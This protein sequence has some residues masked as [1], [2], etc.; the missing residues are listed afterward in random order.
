MLVSSAAFLMFVV[1][2]VIPVT[3]DISG[4]ERD[5]LAFLWESYRSIENPVI[6]IISEI[7][8]SMQTVAYTID[9]IPAVRPF[10]M[11]VS[12]LYAL[13]TV[14]PNVFGQGVHPAIAHGI[15]ADWLVWQVNPEIAAEGG[16]LGYSFIAEAFLNFGWLGAPVMLALIG[17]GLA[18]VF[19]W[20]DRS[21]NRLNIALAAIFVAFLSHFARGESATI[22]RPFVWYGLGPY[23]L[24]GMLSGLLTCWQTAPEHP[25]R[26]GGAPVATATVGSPER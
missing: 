11:G 17:F 20:A 5:S 3:R 13:T 4:S 21:G 24:I 1:F 25:S 14:I 26:N 15:A 22:V 16:G 18:T 12:Y 9:L 8:G 19:L 6:A 10:D 7:G 2:P 23:V